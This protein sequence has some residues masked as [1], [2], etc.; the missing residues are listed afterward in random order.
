MTTVQ[1][2]FDS[3]TEVKRDAVGVINM[4]EVSAVVTIDKGSPKMNSDERKLMDDNVLAV[5]KAVMG[6]GSKDSP[7]QNGTLLA[8]NKQY[9][10]MGHSAEAD[11]KYNEAAAKLY[12]DAANKHVHG[13]LKAVAHFSNTLDP[14]ILVGHPDAIAQKKAALDANLSHSNSADLFEIIPLKLTRD[15]NGHIVNVEVGAKPMVHDDNVEEFLAHFGIKG[16]KWGV[17]REDPSGIN[18]G[19]PSKVKLQ[20]VETG[21]YKMGGSYQ[22]KTKAGDTITIEDPSA[23]DGYR[24]LSKRKSGMW[25]ETFLSEDAKRFVEANQRPQH[26]LSNKD[27]KDALNRAKMIKEYDDIFGDNPTKALEN[28]VK[29]LEAQKK[30][31]TINKEL[32][33]GKI[34]KVNSFVASLNSGYDSYK[35]I[36]KWTEGKLHAKV[37]SNL[38]KIIK[39]L[40]GK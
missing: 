1:S 16:M 3:M 15:N 18:A 25:H 28:K 9:P 27:L 13:G 6:P 21:V 37:S 30:I 23:A 10:P 2:T 14:Y 26:E 12:T 29:Q 33:P 36:D 4:K 39:E 20:K 35:Q 22:R 19:A 17:R 8:L 34:V 31:S 7:H 5:S 38:A 40:K 24:T 11:R 32:N